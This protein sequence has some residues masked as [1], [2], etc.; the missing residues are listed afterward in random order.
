MLSHTVIMRGDIK[1]FTRIKTQKIKITFAFAEYV[2]I[3]LN[4]ENKD[5]YDKWNGQLAIPALNKHVINHVI[6]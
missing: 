3:F 2:K 1:D 4:K 6:T 5:Q